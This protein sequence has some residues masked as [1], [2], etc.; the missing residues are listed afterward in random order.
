MKI[1]NVTIIAFCLLFLNLPNNVLAGDAGGPYIIWVNLSNNSSIEEMLDKRLQADDERVPP[2]SMFLFRKR[3]TNITNDLVRKAVVNNDKT[4]IKKL[5][6]L[7][8]KPF[9]DYKKG[10]DG[11]IVYDE[12]SGPRLSSTTR[13]W[14]SFYREKLKTP[15]DPNSVWELFCKLIPDITRK[16]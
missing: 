1:I 10:F 13:G 4:A 7:I 11:I 3:P 8:R 9:E 14:N 2:D 16:P 6:K 12:V 15:Q 5:D